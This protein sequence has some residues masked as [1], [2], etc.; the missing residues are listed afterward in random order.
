[1]VTTRA[2][3][4]DGAGAFVI[5]EIEVSSP[6][7]DEVLVEIR[8]AGVCHTDHAS[9]SWARPLVMGH[10]GA[11]VVREAGAGVSHVAPGDAVVLNWCIPCGECVQCRQGATVLCEWSRPAHV[12][13]P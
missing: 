8:A 11:G 12:L 10:E 13:R 2:A 5:D 1:M 4:S 3:I 7:E 6:H 9:L